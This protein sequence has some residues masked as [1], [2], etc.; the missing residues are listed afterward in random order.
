MVVSHRRRDR[1]ERCPQQPPSLESLGE[2]VTRANVD[3]FAIFPDTL[4]ERENAEDKVENGVEKGTF[5]ISTL[6]IDIRGPTGSELFL[7]T[8]Q[9]KGGPVGC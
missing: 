4:T 5:S 6:V 8:Q 1:D 9:L 3:W 7:G 2:Y